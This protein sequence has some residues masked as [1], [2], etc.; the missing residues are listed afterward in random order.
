MSK[1]KD[2]LKE[3]TSALGTSEG[4]ALKIDALKSLSAQL[5]TISEL[6]KSGRKEEAQAL[7]KKILSDK[8]MTELK[9]D[10]AIT[11]SNNPKAFNAK[12]A[13][14]IIKYFVQQVNNDEPIN[15]DTLNYLADGFAKYLRVGENLESYLGLTSKAGGQSR[16]PFIV[17]EHVELMVFK[18]IDDGF[19]LSDAAKF[20]ATKKEGEGLHESTLEKNFHKWKGYALLGYK[21]HKEVSSGSP[22][23]LSQSKQEAIN[24]Y[25]SSLIN[26]K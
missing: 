19:S 14:N 11:R 3:L 26:K 9:A 6:Y 13:K 15:K 24:K 18:I 21:C 12:N 20:V 4:I 25:W 16:D 7:K 17:P 22:L 5:S 8:V 10:E 1:T 23:K 2:E